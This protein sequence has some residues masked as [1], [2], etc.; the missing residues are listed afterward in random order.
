MMETP[1]RGMM[2]RPIGLLA[3]TTTRAQAAPEMAGHMAV[4]GVEATAARGNGVLSEAPTVQISVVPA[5]PLPKH[6]AAGRGGSGAAERC[7]AM[8]IPLAVGQ[9]VSTADGRLPWGVVATT[10]GV[11]GIPGAGACE[12]QVKH[13]AERMAVVEAARASTLA[14]RQ[15]THYKCMSCRRLV[16]NDEKTCSACNYTR[17]EGG[18]LARLK[19]ENA[20]AASR[21]NTRKGRRRNKCSDAV[22]PA[23][24]LE[25]APVSP[26]EQRWQEQIACKRQKVEA[27]T[28]AL[29]MARC[30]ET[31]VEC[32]D[33]H[34][35][36]FES[37]SRFCR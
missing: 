32:E 22:V 23:Q 15:V 28:N 36:V 30:G 26:F 4:A 11:V 24:S 29:A 10:S 2:R 21:Q 16:P 17:A 34:A 31:Y 19:Q 27:E 14:K 25:V 37:R 33:S 20:R 9:E 13:V 18:D 12:E 1:A 8:A 35:A 7:S 3:S 6:S 5:L